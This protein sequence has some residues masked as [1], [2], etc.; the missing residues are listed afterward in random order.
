MKLALLLAQYLYSHKKLDLPGIGTF[1]LD[2]SVIIDPEADKNSKPEP[3]EGIRFEY[4]NTIKENTALTE[5]IAAKSG[6]MKALAA[7]DLDSHLW[8]GQQFLNIGKPFVLDGI[9]Q[10]TKTQSGGLDFTAGVLQPEV[11]KDQENFQP[12]A[13]H[14]SQ[15]GEND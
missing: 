7:A 10:L 2:P 4:N 1:H 15:K 3:I 8:L 12:M 14:S 5:Y 11:L 6:K 13:D 9:G